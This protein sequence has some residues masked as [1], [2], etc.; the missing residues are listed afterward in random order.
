L[1]YTVRGEGSLTGQE[2]DSASPTREQKATGGKRIKRVLRGPQG[3]REIKPE[4][5][6]SQ[7]EPEGGRSLRR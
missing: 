1:Y 2:K 6:L 5:K 4:K 7:S 3:K